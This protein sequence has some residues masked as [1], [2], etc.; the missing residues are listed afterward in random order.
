MKI[1]SFS[2]PKHPMDVMPTQEI[3]P[4]TY[5][6]VTAQYSSLL[7]RHFMPGVW[8][9][10]DGKYARTTTKEQHEE[11]ILRTRQKLNLPRRASH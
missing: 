11:V 4:P 6:P 1:S 9:A 7:R 2:A 5:S 8:V 10:P 3:N